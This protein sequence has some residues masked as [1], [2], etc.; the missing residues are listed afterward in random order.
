[1]ELIIDGAACDLGGP[2]AVPGYDA[3]TLADPASAHGRRTLLLTLPASPRNDA[4]LGDPRDPYTAQRFAEAA[5]R[6]SVTA[7][8]AVLLEGAA[9]L[10]AASD[11][12]FR[13]EIREE[14][15]RWMRE[16]AR[17]PLRM[18][19]I[20]YS[21]NLNPAVIRASWTEPT[22]VRF[23]PIVRDE[24]P[25]Q[26]A[27]QDLLPAERI[28][29]VDDYHPFLHVATLLEAI[30]GQAGY[31][32]QSRFC[33]SEF[34]RSLYMS[35]AYASRDTTAAESRMGFHA[36][37]LGPASAAA[38][39]IGRVYADPKR[40]AATVGNLVETATPQTPDADGTPVAGLYNNGGCFTVEEGKIRFTPTT[41]VTVGFEYRLK[42][43]TGHR[44]RD[45]YRLTGF[46]TLYLGPGSEVRFTLA[47]R[48]EDRRGELRS[49]YSYRAVVFD[50]AAG[51]EYRLLYTRNGVSASEWSTFAARTAAVT[52]PAS[53][54]VERPVLEIRTA[55]GWSPY[56]GDWALYDGYVGEVGETTVELRVRTA[57]RSFGPS[58]PAT[59]D[60]IYFA[61]AEPGMH[62]TLHKECALRTRFTAGPGYGSALTFDDV[63]RHDIR[64]STLVEALGHLFNLRFWTD[65]ATRTVRIEPADDFFG[66][67]DCPAIVD[68]RAKSDFTRPVELADLAPGLCEAEIWRYAA[69]DGPVA[70]FDQKAGVNDSGTG[71]AGPLGAWRFEPGGGA[72]EEG[73]R[74]HR[75]PLFH[76]ALNVAGR[77]LNAPSASLLQLGD[78]D[79][80]DG[81][82]APATP[83]IVRY[84]GMHPLPQNERWGAPWNE[85]SYPLAAFHYE[86]DTHVAPF[87]LCFEDRDGATGLHSHYDRQL[88]QEASRQR[89]TLSLRIEPREFEAL[90]N[91][92]TGEADLRALF[93]LDTGRGEVLATLDAV[94]P[95]DPEAASVRCS[96][97]RLTEDAR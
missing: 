1:M 60:G 48:Y 27:S 29:S 18:L 89:I 66:G 19:D 75:N 80:A 50:H 87:T 79:A 38:D 72:A 40:L 77:Y 41:A 52:T 51:A 2:A 6:A 4:V 14:G 56:E 46:D 30:V 70:R 78:R 82:A 71:A 88:A 28:L 31:T 96:F 64:Q 84:V 44:I 93:R 47:N 69:S 59:F 21:A 95:Y 8:G 33:A 9:R 86:G 20:A 39:E 53:G 85:S 97:R 43:T 49:G 15:A 91:P 76:P 45:R 73:S 36:R 42:Y 61:G 63:A 81:D 7:G 13:L 57:G 25:Q 62:L 54:T 92:G 11:E 12:G 65:E 34:F 16:A 90:L 24:Y 68:W 32:L 22:P 26:N 37:R 83:R 17:R 74:T 35:G 23:F 67:A 58:A 94:G 3:S 55:S 5:H 10:L